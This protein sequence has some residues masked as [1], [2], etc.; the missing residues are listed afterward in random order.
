MKKIL[1]TNDDGIEASGI[2]RLARSAL[3]YGEVWIAAP[4]CQRSGVSHSMNYHSPFEVR[5]ASFPA[6]VAKAYAVDGSPADCVRV[7]VL[8]LMPEKPDIVL[9]GINRGYNAGTDIMYSGTVGAAFEA[10]FQGIPAIAFS[11]G[12]DGAEEITNI[13]LDEIMGI[14]LDMKTQPDEI[15]NIN[16]P[17]C[18]PSEYNGILYDRFMSHCCN[19]FHNYKRDVRP[20]GTVTYAVDS[21]YNGVTEEGS[22]LRALNEHFISIGT[23]KNLR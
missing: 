6:D 23:I 9:S 7:G 11:E 18:T 3:K 2:I 1:I 5:E 15:L 4:T 20:D 21:V 19:C 13:Y 10:V 14:A 8:A 16:F 12:T 17:D 22:D